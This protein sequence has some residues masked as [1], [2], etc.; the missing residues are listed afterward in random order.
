MNHLYEGGTENETSTF[1][2]LLYSLTSNLPN[3]WVSPLPEKKISERILV[4]PLIFE[5]S[6]KMFLINIKKKLSIQYHT[7]LPE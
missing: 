1:N 3:T 7:F 2:R 5:T 6:E 4:L